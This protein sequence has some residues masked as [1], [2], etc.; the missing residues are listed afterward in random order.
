MEKRE[1]KKVLFLLTFLFLGPNRLLWLYGGVVSTFIKKMCALRLHKWSISIS[2]GAVISE[3][4]IFPHPQNIV[5]GRGVR[6]ASGAIIYQGVTLGAKN[7]QEKIPE[8]KLYDKYPKVCKGAVI[9][10]NSVLVGGITIEENAIVGANSFVNSS[11]KK[12]SVV[13]GNPAVCI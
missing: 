7:G 4:A 9:Y 13:V 12:G 2:E 5:I 11:V 10:T 8:H 3:N 6:I 1:I